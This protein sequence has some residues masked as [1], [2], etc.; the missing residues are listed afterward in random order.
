M[1]SAV[2]LPF[3][4]CLLV[5]FEAHLEC[6]LLSEVLLNLASPHLDS[7]GI[8]PWAPCPASLCLTSPAACSEDRD[9]LLR[10][11]WEQG[12][13][14]SLHPSE[15]GCGSHP[16]NLMR[17]SPQGHVRLTVYMHSLQH[18]QLHLLVQCLLA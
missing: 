8:P 6:L 5:F 13:H 9:S 2:P 3:L 11:C 17:K 4:G 10:M 12:L 15:H 1:A 18:T 16:G 14:D 7:L